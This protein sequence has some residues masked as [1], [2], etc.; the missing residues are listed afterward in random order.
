MGGRGTFAAG[1]NVEYKYDTVEDL[2]C[3]LA[4]KPINVVN[5]L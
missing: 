1:K 5:K 3:F 2:R 4:G